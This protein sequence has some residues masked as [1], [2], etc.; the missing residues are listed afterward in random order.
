MICGK[1]RL[2]FFQD[3]HGMSCKAECFFHFLAKA[4]V[5]LFQIYKWHKENKKSI[6]FFGGIF[7][8]SISSIYFTLQ[9]K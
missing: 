4:V 3:G 8:Q 6:I 7:V 5:A 9:R 1:M 2:T